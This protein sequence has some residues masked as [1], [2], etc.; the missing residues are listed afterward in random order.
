LPELIHQPHYCFVLARCRSLLA[1]DRGFL[2]QSK[3]SGS[4]HNVNCHLNPA[5]VKLGS[6]TTPRPHSCPLQ[7]RAG[8]KA[9]TK[10]A[11][12]LLT[13]EQPQEQLQGQRWRGGNRRSNCKASCD[14]KPAP[15]TG[16]AVAPTAGAA[17]AAAMAAA[18]PPI[19]TG[20]MRQ[21]LGPWICSIAS[22]APTARSLT[23]T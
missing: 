11:P 18:A 13:R 23:T 16:R 2:A 17:K 15:A 6:L 20:G 7:P 9:N 19:K 5:W 4:K 1:S 3:P 8:E 22:G 14:T 21:G 12:A 10:P